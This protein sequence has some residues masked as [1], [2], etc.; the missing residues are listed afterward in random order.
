MAIQFS[1]NTCP[2]ATSCPQPD[3]PTQDGCP[4]GVCP[5]FTIRRHDT[6]PFFRVNVEDCDGPIDLTGLVL[7][8]NMWAIAKLK[9]SIDETATYFALADAI[10][11]QQINVGD[12]IIFDRVRNPEH[13]LV[14]GFDEVNFLVLVQRG[15]NGTVPGV[16]RKGQVMRIFRILNAPAVTEMSFSDVE[17]VDGTTLNNQLTDSFLVYE[18]TGMD[19]CLPGCFWMEFKLL[20]MK[21]DSLFLPGGYWSGFVNTDRAGNHFTGTVKSSSSVL[22]SLDPATT[23]LLLPTNTVWGGPFQTWTDGFIY[24]GTDHDD[25]SVQLD[26]T[27]ISSDPTVEYNSGLSAISIDVDNV[28][29]T[30][31][32]ISCVPGPEISSGTVSTVPISFTVCSDTVTACSIGDGVEWVRRFPVQGEGFL[33]KIVDS[34]T[35][36]H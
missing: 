24:T 10:G 3:C 30:T 16:W 31:T 28:I 32:T 11:F 19:T 36:E 7:E 23:H 15:Y 29:S 22:L 27:G 25:G 5:D 26:Q 35:A 20:K 33:V 2:G 17:Q 4:P 9:K 13:M 12:V 21:A 18:W 14:E 8:V 6:K 1:N 34:S